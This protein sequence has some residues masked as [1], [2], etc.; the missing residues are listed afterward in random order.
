[1]CIRDRPYSS[2]AVFAGDDRLLGEDCT[3]TWECYEEFCREEAFWLEDYALYCVLKEE[4]SGLPWQ[5]WPQPERDRTNLD[6]WKHSASRRLEAVRRR[7][8]R[9][10]SQWDGIRAY[11][12]QK[13]IAIIGDLPICAGTDSADTWACL[14]YT[15]KGDNVYCHRRFGAHKDRQSGQSGYRFTVWAPGAKSVRV[16]GSFDGWQGRAYSMELLDERGIWEV[17][18]PHAEEGM[19]YKYLIETC[20]GDQLYKADPDVYKRQRLYALANLVMLS[21][22]ITTSFPCSTRRWARASTISATFT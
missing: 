4:F 19:L 12:N 1:M 20:S 2:P 14:L 9:F 8:F 5:K 10:W 11:A 13:G 18:V 21:R 6:Q 3:L 16:T 15:S 17:F 22:R 7:Q